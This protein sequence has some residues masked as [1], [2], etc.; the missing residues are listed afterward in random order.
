MEPTETPAARAIC[1]VVGHVA[2]PSGDTLYVR[3]RKAPAAAIFA[4]FAYVDPKLQALR[5]L[6]AIPK[7]AQE[8]ELSSIVARAS[9]SSM[10]A[11]SK[12]R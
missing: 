4:W 6:G 10:R 7:T 2:L 5:F 1:R 3:S 8:G 9:T 11:R 12:S